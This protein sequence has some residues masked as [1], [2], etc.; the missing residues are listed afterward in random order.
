MPGGFCSQSRQYRF[1]IFGLDPLRSLDRIRHVL[2]QSRDFDLL[3]GRDHSKF[4]R[5]IHLKIETLVQA[6]YRFDRPIGKKPVIK[7]TLTLKFVFLFLRGCDYSTVFQLFLCFA[8]LCETFYSQTTVAILGTINSK[9]I[10]PN[11]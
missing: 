4:R 8:L 1:A 2:L 6:L 3:A 9:A 10:T 7:E 11:M 5:Q